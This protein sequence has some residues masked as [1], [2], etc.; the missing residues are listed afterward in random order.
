MMGK[1]KI[2]IVGIGNCASSLIQGIN[3]YQLNSDENTSGLMHKTIGDYSVSEI[4][5][6]AAVD[7]DKRKVGLKLS[8]A[9]FAKPN[10]TKIFCKEFVIKDVEVTMG[11]ILD[12]YSDH[13]KNYPEERTFV[14]ASCPESSFDD[15]VSLLKESKAEMLLNYLP[16]GS[17]EATGFYAKCALEAG[18]AFIN[19]IPVFIASNPTWAEGFKKKNIPIIGDDIKSQIGATII[20]RTLADLFHK[21]GVKFEK[22]YQLNIG[23]NTDFLNMLNQDRLQ[24]KRESKTEAVKAAAGTNLIEEN[25]RIGPS[26]YV[27]WQNDNKICYIRMEGKLFGD[28]PMNL[29]L[30]LSVEDSPCC[31]GVV[32]DAIRCCKLALDRGVGGVLFSPSAYFMKHPP[33]QFNDDEAYRMIKEFIE[34]IRDV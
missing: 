33:K 31:A 7:I 29:E 27:P 16:V 34:G 15:I 25:I 13:M 5:V 6:V 1:I 22:T 23:G 2:A 14:P 3:Y 4:E 24:S 9:I 18:T 11:R 26:D 19:N 8:E 32:I 12:G 28:V 20:H 17:E 10:C 30:R 21:R